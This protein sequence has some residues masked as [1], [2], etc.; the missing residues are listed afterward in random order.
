METIALIICLIL[1]VLDG[2]GKWYTIVDLSKRRMRLTDLEAEKDR[3][4]HERQELEA[5]REKA[6]L[7]QRELSNDCRSMAE[8]L[9]RVRQEIETLQS[10]EER[11]RGPGD[12]ELLG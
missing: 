8:D 9:S 7:K 5:A 6:H 4:R 10:D 12:D 2:L 1:A 3:L 11:I